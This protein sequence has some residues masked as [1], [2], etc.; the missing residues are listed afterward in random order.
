L[1]LDEP[2]ENDDQFEVDGITYLV[3]KGLSAMTGKIKLDYVDSR[4]S[5]GFA[6]TSEKP[7]GGASGCG[8]SCSC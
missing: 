4:W 8:S 7:V 2:K 3:D 6:I 1:V 5:K